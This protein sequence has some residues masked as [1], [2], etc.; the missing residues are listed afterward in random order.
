MTRKIEQDPT[1][2]S[3]M[4]FGGCGLGKTTV[5]AKT[6]KHLHVIHRLPQYVIYVV[7]EQDNVQSA[8]DEL[9]FCGMPTHI[10]GLKA[11]KASDGSLPLLPFKINVMKRGLLRDLFM[12]GRGSQRE[13]ILSILHNLLIVYDEVDTLIRSSLQGATA[14]ELANLVPLSL[15][16]SATLVS[17]Q[18]SEL[19]LP[20]M[21]L[22]M[23]HVP[24]TKDNW[25][26]VTGNLIRRYVPLEFKAEDI[27]H[28]VDWPADHPPLDLLRQQAKAD[29]KAA[30]ACRDL[31]YE[32]I[33]S[34]LSKDARELLG[35]GIPV[36]IRA[37]TKAQRD[38]LVA[39][40]IKAGYKA[41]D[42]SH[43]K[44]RTYVCIVATLDHNARGINGMERFCHVL[45]FELPSDASTRHQ[46][47][48]RFL[49]PGQLSPVVY[50][51]Q[52][53]IPGSGVERLSHSH[54]YSDQLNRSIRESGDL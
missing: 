31:E 27:V 12:E 3:W 54:A 32:V 18:R 36:M 14:L 25:F 42:M 22:F 53:V 21:R 30:S 17:N 37:K 52:Y 44:D 49:R 40:L 7:P 24:I 2:P 38:R 35:K 23:P 20:W 43:L 5:L 11:K 46:W 41:G 16:A 47:R 13:F 34:A 48:G 9:K 4:V 26:M 28:T 19:Y 50:F 6:I 15:C 45:E 33:E 8:C 29:L 10:V 39:G 51:H 1:V